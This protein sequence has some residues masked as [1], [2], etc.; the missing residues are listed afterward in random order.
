MTTVLLETRGPV[1]MVTI[2]RPEVRNAVERTD[3]ARPG[4]GLSSL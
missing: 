1:A 2:N 4:G 3:R